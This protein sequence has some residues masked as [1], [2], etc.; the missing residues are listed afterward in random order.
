MYIHFGFVLKRSK[1]WKHKEAILLQLVVLDVIC[2]ELDL[3][4]EESFHMQCH[5]VGN[6]T[7]LRV[8]FSFYSVSVSTST[9]QPLSI[10]VRSSFTRTGVASTLSQTIPE[11]SESWISQKR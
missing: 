2:H 5:V 4:R 8:K 1:F 10:K 11:D 9:P 3:G 6:I 7:S